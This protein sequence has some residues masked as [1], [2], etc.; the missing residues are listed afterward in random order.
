MTVETRRVPRVSIVIV[1]YHGQRFWDDLLVGLLNQSYDDWEL[2]V[3]DNGG[4]LR[5]PS[6]IGNNP[7]RI[8]R[9]HENLGFADGCNVGVRESRGCYIALLNNDTTVPSMWLESLV[10]AMD[11]DERVGALC[12]KVLFESHF[13][14][15]EL[16]S[17]RFVP[18][19]LGVGPDERS[20]GLRVSVPS[21]YELG[22]ISPNSEGLYAVERAGRESWVWTNGDARFWIPAQGE[23]RFTIMLSSHDSLCG[24]EFRIKVGKVEAIHV[25]QTEGNR[26]EICV[27][28]DATFDVLNNVGNRI[29]SNWNF[30]E[31]GLNEKDAGQFD[32]TGQ[33]G[34]ICGCSSLIRKSALSNENIFD[35]EF[36]A[37][38]EDSD[39][40]LRLK[41]AGWQLLYE[42]TSVVRHYGSATAGVQSAFQV[43][44]ATRNRFWVIAKHAPWKVVC[45]MMTGEM[46][47]LSSYEPWL[48]EEY[49]LGRL[50]RET[51]SGFIKHLC[52]RLC[53][54]E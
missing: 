1:D 19:E 53:D 11:L 9:P 49:S 32:R 8:I 30:S 6:G 3:V 15:V 26:I 47:K 37:Y 45:K 22:L 21:P 5:L 29:D 10:R 4:E 17:C 18:C 48:D 23:G 7:V 38:F 14:E 43:F 31:I 27:P 34:L 46:L 39:L 13:I 40:S 28:E 24:T 12:S 51:W 52:R 33:I 35:P 20:L 36:F 25:L 44:H 54:S 41:K 42:P 50:K 16:T 2:I